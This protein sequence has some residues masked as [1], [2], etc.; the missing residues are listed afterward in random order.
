MGLKILK[1]GGELCVI[2]YN[3]GQLALGQTGNDLLSGSHLGGIAEQASTGVEDNGIAALEEQGGVGQ[4][5]TLVE[6][7]EA[8]ALVELTFAHGGH[9]ALAQ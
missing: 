1:M 3:S 8:V 5:K 9:D 2:L 7:V 6:E 4:A